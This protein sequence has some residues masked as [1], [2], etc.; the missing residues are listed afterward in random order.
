MLHSAEVSIGVGNTLRV[1]ENVCH[2]LQKDTVFPF[3][4]SVPL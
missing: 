2:F 4:F 1:L 3:D